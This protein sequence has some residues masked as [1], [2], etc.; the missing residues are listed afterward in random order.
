MFVTK[1]AAVRILYNAKVDKILPKMRKLITV[2][3]IAVGAAILA[4]A[5]IASAKTATTTT[6]TTPAA[7]QPMILQVNKD[8]KALLRGTIASISNGVLTVNSWGGTWTVNVG[9][10]AQILPASAG[11]DITQFKTGDFVGV[12][13]TIAQGSLW[14][15]NATLIRDWTYR[16]AVNTEVRQNVQEAKQI[17][18]ANRPRDYV[19]VASGVNGT[20]FTLTVGG[21][22]YTVDVASGAEVV[23]RTWIAMPISNIQANDNVRV[24]G[25]ASSSTITAQIVRDVSIPAK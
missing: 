5:L 20:S 17:R 6:T 13:G 8:G 4:T 23:N 10:S 14:T 18:N 11:N 12:E 16:T 1:E 15:V 7:S 3:G 9:S 25:V 21:T 2:A 19:G 24:W 22:A